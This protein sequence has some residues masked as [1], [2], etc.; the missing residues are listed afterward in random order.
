ML[1]FPSVNSS[2]IGSTHI[3]LWG[4][5][6]SSG[7]FLPAQRSSPGCTVSMM[8]AG[9][10]ERRERVERTSSSKIGNCCFN[11]V[12]FS[13][14]CI[15]KPYNFCEL[16]IFSPNVMLCWYPYYVQQLCQALW[17]P[18]IHANAYKL[19]VGNGFIKVFQAVVWVNTRQV[20]STVHTQVLDTL[21]SLW[22]EGEGGVKAIRR[23]WGKGVGGKK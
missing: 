19:S 16:N 11:K 17:K 6:G 10:W 21:V 12:N 22:G 2:K 3:P 8:A 23:V 13:S 15:T 20:G 4:Q 7:T 1:V 5:K 9:D 14:I 18:T